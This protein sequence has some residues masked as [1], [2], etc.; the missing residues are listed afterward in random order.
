MEL[1]D[2]NIHNALIREATIRV[3]KAYKEKNKYKILIE[4]MF[5]KKGTRGQDFSKYISNLLEKGKN[6][7]GDLSSLFRTDIEVREGILLLNTT[8]V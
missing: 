6:F 2:F 4:K 1:E 5:S 7:Y 3:L 8:I